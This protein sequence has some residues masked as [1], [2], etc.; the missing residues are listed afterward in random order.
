MNDICT[1]IFKTTF[2]TIIYSFFFWNKIKG[3]T[4]SKK[5]KRE[6]YQKLSQNSYTN[7]IYFY[8]NLKIVKTMFVLIQTHETLFFVNKCS[9][10]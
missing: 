6:T 7:I 4:K 1:F 3:E 9:N 5:Y 8:I 2:A 10:S